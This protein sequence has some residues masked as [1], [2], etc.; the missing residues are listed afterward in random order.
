[1]MYFT[2]LL[3]SALVTWQRQGLIPAYPPMIGQEAAQVGSAL[4][5]DRDRDFVFPTYREL[6]VAVAW[7]V[8]LSGYLANHS[9]HWHGGR[10]N[11]A[12]SRF[13]PIQ[14]VVGGGV[15][16][17]VGWALGR[18]LDGASAVAIA[19]LG[20]GASSEGDV[21]EAMNFAAVLR[22]P[23]VFFVQNNRWSL[24]VPLE[25]QV[26]GG[27]VAARAAGYGIPGV[28]VDG[29]DLLAVYQ[30]TSDAAAHARSTGGPIIVEAMTYRRG[31]HA[32]SDDTGR[33]RTIDDELSAG[34]DPLDRLL[35]TLHEA[36]IADDAWLAEVAQN[37][38]V[39]VEELRLSTAGTEPIHGAEMFDLVFAESTPQLQ[40]QQA[41]WREESDHV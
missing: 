17:A 13:A 36:G 12:E 3:D 28:V 33:Y 27:S 2:R 30:A 4:A 22:A 38:E 5:L 32:T 40:R 6:G 10:W 20:D 29:D 7:G 21:H 26:A 41:H 24:S 14:A 15:T 18:R 19:Y 31:P 37:A 16:H 39:R 35:A 23:V 8:D 9:G 25:R 1:M 34:E 11:A